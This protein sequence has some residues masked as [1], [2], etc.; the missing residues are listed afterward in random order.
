MRRSRCCGVILP[1]CCQFGQRL[2]LTLAETARDYGLSFSR[3]VGHRDRSELTPYIE[4][5]LEFG[6]Q[7][8][9]AR[10]TDPRCGPVAS[11][12]EQRRPLPIRARDNHFH[13][14]GALLL[15]TAVLARRR[16]RRHPKGCH[17]IKAHVESP[18]T[19]CLRPI[20]I[21]DQQTPP[22]TPSILSS[23]ARPETRSEFQLN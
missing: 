12:S 16:F 20:A 17:T 19:G 5:T 15:A 23:R 10:R 2:Q 11:A 14:T 13:S 8:L 9:I 4:Q 6:N 1:R 7:A 18:L 21:I 22:G 3:S